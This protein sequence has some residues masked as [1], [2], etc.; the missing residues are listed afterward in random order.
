MENKIRNVLSQ[1]LD[2]LIY[3]FGFASLSG[4]LSDKY[5]S[6]ISGISIIRKLD[7]SVIDS[8][9]DG[10]TVEYYNHYC[11]VNNELNN[12]VSQIAD[13]LSALSLNCRPIKATVDDYELEESYFKTLTYDF[14][15]KMAATRAG[16][17]WIGKT[18]LLISKRFGPRIRMASILTDFSFKYT[19]DPIETSLCR[20]CSLCVEICPANAANGKA[21]NVGIKRDD[22]F[23]PFKCR[24]YCKS[25]SFEKLK[26]SISLC[27]KC[28]FVCPSG[29]NQ[30]R[31]V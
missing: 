1:N 25:I 2:P 13:K 20:N 28:V 24:D 11:E 16:L 19:N 7:D 4:L 17:G 14:S 8:I 30:S 31:D 5:S 12:A 21:W 15:H 26:K 9:A 6:Y 3:E 10:P 22:F 29:K 18:D 27:A 23:N